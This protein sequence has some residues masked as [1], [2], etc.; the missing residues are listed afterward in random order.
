[1]IKALRIPKQYGTY[2]DICLMLGLAQ[3]S[4][5]AQ[6]QIH[7]VKTIELADL[8]TNYRI[9]L[10]RELNP[11]EIAFTVHY[12][13][14]LLCPVKGD[15]TKAIAGL[16]WSDVDFFNTKEKTETRNRY[17]EFQHQ[18]KR[19]KLELADEDKPPEPD[20]RTQNGVILTSMRHDRNHNALWKAGWDIRQHFGALVASVFKAFA[21]N[22]ELSK[23]N[24]IAQAAAYFKAYTGEPLPD[25][26]SAVKIFFPTFVQGVN[27]L[28]ADT[29]KVDGSGH[30]RDWLLLWL[31]AA[32]LFE[33]GIAERI[34]VSDNTFDWRMVMMEPKELS[35]SSYREV[36]D[37]VRKFSPPSGAH[38]VARF[39]AEMS[40]GL[41]QQLLKHHP[42]K[43]VNQL[44][45]Q[46]SRSPS[47]KEMVSGFSGTH[48][49]SKGQV[50]G[51]K[52][53]FSLGLPD[54]IRPETA[55]D[56]K[57]YR[58]LLDEHLAI[59]RSL[60]IDEGNGE[61]LNA[62][63]DFITGNELNQFFRFNI[64]YSDYIVRQLADPKA[65]YAPRR[66]SQEGLDIMTRSFD[67]ADQKW[68]IK[69]ITQNKGFLRI[70][71]AINSATVYAGKI[72]TKE[73]T[74]E[75]DWQRTYGLA[76]RLSNQLGSKQDFITELSAF[77]TSYDNENVRISEQ[78]LKDN[79]SL[80]RVW[81]TNE[82]LEEFLVL[83]DDGQP[84]KW[85]LV[86][87]LLLAYGYTK[88]KK[89][90]EGEPE[91]APAGDEDNTDE[92]E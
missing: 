2:A 74:V 35:F 10:E 44:P 48:F 9:Y 37:E 84:F 86:A 19:E 1:M 39:D 20:A 87:N 61:L 34:K 51:V 53:V 89:P 65:K 55:E 5:I 67:K 38:G 60:S 56:I 46:R 91:G 92:G 64:S 42:A 4:Y 27:R 73:G 59:V 12:D 7:D 79:K 30:K 11:E 71:R 6:R 25:P 45:R 50:Y 36:L 62:Y 78:L 40:I 41:S 82:D 52:E 8:G 33:F 68:S 54:W 24:E 15:K 13:N 17:R 21:D 63:R 90:L 88:W 31:I 70:A 77:L 18:S 69:D 81:V 32:G 22:D 49:G 72:K 28:K 66:F 43:F 75:L 80:R 57:N 14:L 16:N 58:K 83:L 85:S 29:N 23:G 3:L 47:I 76:Q 26:A